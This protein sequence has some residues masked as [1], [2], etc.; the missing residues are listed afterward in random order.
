MKKGSVIGEWIL[1][2]TSYKD[3]RKS[4]T[5]YGFDQSFW[6]ADGTES[7]N[8]MFLILSW[9]MNFDCGWFW[10]LWRIVWTTRRVNIKF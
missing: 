1:L 7:R 4:K 8:G 2:E 5:W 9:G 6:W 10:R 3:E